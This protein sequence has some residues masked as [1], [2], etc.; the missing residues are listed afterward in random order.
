MDI[1]II[2]KIA[3]IGLIVAILNQILVKSGREDYAL[4]AAL[5]GIAVVLMMLLPQLSALLNGIQ[6]IFNF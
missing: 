2:I 6:T 5:A 4:V 3:I 1:D